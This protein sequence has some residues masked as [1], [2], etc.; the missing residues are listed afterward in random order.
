MHEP[1][2][3]PVVFFRVTR[4]SGVPHNARK[5][6]RRFV[7]AGDDGPPEMA[8]GANF[9]TLPELRQKYVRYVL[10]CCHGERRKAAR[11][12]G[13]GKVTLYRYLKKHS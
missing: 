2:Q 8:S 12:L 13:I 6:E 9:L 10:E 11:I 5:A 4:E 7:F 1:D 3:A